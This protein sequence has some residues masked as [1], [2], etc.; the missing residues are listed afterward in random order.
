[1]TALRFACEGA[2]DMAVVDKVPERLADLKAE[3]SACG[4][5][6]ITIEADLRDLDAAR[7]CALQAIDRL[8]GI[9]VLI[10]NAGASALQSF[11]DTTVET[12]QTVFTV[13]LFSSFVIGQEVARDM[14][15]R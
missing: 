6:A 2:T 7:S 10:S 11:V 13:N 8:G 5:D 9:D 4:A 3:L 14:I 1:A 12:L 15:A